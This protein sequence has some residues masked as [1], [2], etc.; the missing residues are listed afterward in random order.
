MSRLWQERAPEFVSP[1]SSSRRHSPRPFSSTPSPATNVRSLW[2][3]PVVAAPQAPGAIIP[4]LRT[5]AR[6]LVAATSPLVSS[7]ATSSNAILF[8]PDLSHH[9]TLS[10]PA[11]QCFP[12][13]HL[14]SQSLY[15]SE[16]CKIHDTDELSASASNSSYFPSSLSTSPCPSPVFGPTKTSRH[17]QHPARTCRSSQRSSP[18]SSPSLLNSDIPDLSD[19]DALCDRSA[20]DSTFRASRFRGSKQTVLDNSM[21]KGKPGVPQAIPAV[22][23][24]RHGQGSKSMPGLH[25]IRKPGPINSLGMMAAPSSPSSSHKLQQAH[26]RFGSDAQMQYVLPRNASGGHTADLTYL[27]SQDRDSSNSG[28]SS[29][30]KSK[31]VLRLS[32]SSKCG[33][34]GHPFDAIPGSGHSTRRVPSFEP[35]HVSGSQVHIRRQLSQNQLFPGQASG[36]AAAVTTHLSISHP[37]DVLPGAV[38]GTTVSKKQSAS[39]LSTLRGLAKAHGVSQSARQQTQTTPLECT[40]SNTESES[41]RPSVATVHLSNLWPKLNPAP[42]AGPRQVITRPSYAMDERASPVTSRRK[43][44]HVRT[45]ESHTRMQHSISPTGDE[46][47]GDDRSTQYRR[48]ARFH[49]PPDEVGPQETRRGRSRQR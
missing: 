14:P 33:I 6:Q 10:N 2:T 43:N 39:A 4:V 17:A 46:Y 18:T 20:L 15:C 48:A 31:N 9:P 27:N 7:L 16:E 23:H 40:R 32:P 30:P 22:Q 41:D 42:T 36:L 47:S 5:G 37:H 29:T 11:P 34:A 24:S 28:L 38:R 25:Y 19:E 12:R 26:R 35:R 21:W 8:L 3:D 1:I 13:G 49:D 45:R 44:D